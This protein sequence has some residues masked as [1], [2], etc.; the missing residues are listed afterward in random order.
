MREWHILLNIDFRFQVSDLSSASGVAE[1][2]IISTL[3]TMQLIKYW[4]GD[5]VVRMTRRL[6]EHCKS[7]N[8]GRP[9]NLEILVEAISGSDLLPNGF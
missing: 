2:D 7:I 1:D 5:H 4:K 9:P 8:M 6:V 3:Q